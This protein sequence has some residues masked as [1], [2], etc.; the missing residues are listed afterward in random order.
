[1][2]DNKK[3]L[4]VEDNETL[5]QMY[6]DNFTLKGLEVKR[7]NDG[8]AAVAEA[9][10]F[11]PALILLDIMMPNING[12]EVLKILRTSNHTKDIPVFMM[13]A[14]SE[15]EE[16]EKAMRLG[17]TD[18]LVKAEE[19]LPTVTAKVLEKLGLATAN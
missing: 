1:M 12:F 7:V 11:Q 4:I 9:V 19:D 13:T 6:E 2:A 15:T 17:A 5:G 16:R 14:L 8:E 3:L 18:Y 10:N